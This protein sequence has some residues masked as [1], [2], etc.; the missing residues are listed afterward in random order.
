MPLSAVVFLSDT[1]LFV[2]PP[3][4]SVITMVRSLLSGCPLLGEFG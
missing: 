2:D 4:I 3:E 1:K